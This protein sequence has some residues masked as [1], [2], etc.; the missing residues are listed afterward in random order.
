[1]KTAF[2]YDAGSKKK[3]G[4]KE[5]HPG[6]LLRKSK[7]KLTHCYSKFAANLNS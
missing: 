4:K 3:A 6:Q 5:I 2:F 7:Q 1:M